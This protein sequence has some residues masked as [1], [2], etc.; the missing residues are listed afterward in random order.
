[1]LVP[2]PAVLLL[3]SCLTGLMLRTSARLVQQ[4]TAVSLRRILACRQGG[5]VSE[6]LWLLS[7][8]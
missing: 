4:V 1:M 5:S 6:V 8:R 2:F 3:I 7:G